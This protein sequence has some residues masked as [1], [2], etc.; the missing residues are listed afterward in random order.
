[1]EEIVEAVI[2]GVSWMGKVDRV[3]ETEEG[4]TVVDYKT[5][6]TAA[7]KE[8]AAESLQLGFYATALGAGRTVTRAE[9]WFPRVNTRSV[10]TRSLDMSRLDEVKEQMAQVAVSVRSEAWEPT[11][12]SH[13][14]RCQFRLSCPAWPEGRGAYL[15]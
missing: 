5:S 3:E 15:T 14:R 9:M 6:S 4:L 2:E 13:C 12:G 8:E 7:T 10:S 11:P 1:V